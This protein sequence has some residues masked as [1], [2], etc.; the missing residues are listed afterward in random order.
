M[1]SGKIKNAEYFKAGETL[2]LT[3][4]TLSGW[5]NSS[6]AACVI[7]LLLP[8]KTKTVPAYSATGTIEA[9]GPGGGRAA[10]ITAAAL[11]GENLV[12]FTLSFASN[13]SPGV[14][15]CIRFNAFALTF[16]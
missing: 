9:Y 3:G 14:A 5:T 10:T 7:G 16:S 15:V 13:F 4:L 11:T 8:K 2:D 6:G 1:A 12:L